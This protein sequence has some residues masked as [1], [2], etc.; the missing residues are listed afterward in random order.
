ME[1]LVHPVVVRIFEVLE[2]LS[3]VYI[4]TEFATSGELFHKI[5]SDG[6]FPESTAKVYYAQILSGVS[7]MVGLRSLFLIAPAPGQ[8]KG[9][10]C[11]R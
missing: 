5:I 3:Q 10:H 4:V 2:T 11:D 9:D 1:K 8:I 6:K 7:H